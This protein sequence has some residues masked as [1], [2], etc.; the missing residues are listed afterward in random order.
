MKNVEFTLLKRDLNW[1]NVN[2]I[3][4]HIKHLME[5]NNSIFIS[6]E[7]LKSIDKVASKNLESLYTEA[8]LENKKLTVLAHQNKEI[9][10]AMQKNN[11]DYIVE[12]DCILENK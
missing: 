2:L 1:E 3:R 7:K 5:A 10:N 12:Y 6:I 9:K 4:N 11:T 8:T